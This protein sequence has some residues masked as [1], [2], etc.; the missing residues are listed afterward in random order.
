M[1][2]DARAATGASDESSSAHEHAAPPVARKH[3][4]QCCQE[5]PIGWA[6]AWSGHLPAQQSE[7]VTQDQDLDL[8]RGL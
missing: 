7:L 1:S 3:P 5:H 2:N 4:G 6:A 8:V